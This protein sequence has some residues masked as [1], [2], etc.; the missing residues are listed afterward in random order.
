MKKLDMNQLYQSTQTG[1]TA[2]EIILDVREP[3][4]FAEGH[5]PKATNFPL[6]TLPQ[7]INDLQ[8]FKTIY[9]HCRAGGRAQRAAEFLKSA[10]LHNLACVADGG[11]PEWE[12]AGFPVERG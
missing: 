9:I 3:D 2:D 6:G 1:L 12:A 5:I 7:R 4:E 10:G 8:K 11:F